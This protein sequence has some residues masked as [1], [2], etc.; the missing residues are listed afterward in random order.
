MLEFINKIKYLKVMFHEFSD[1]LKRLALTPVM[2]DQINRRLLTTGIID[3]YPIFKVNEHQVIAFRADVEPESDTP[4]IAIVDI[5]NGESMIICSGMESFIPIWIITLLTNVNSRQ[6]IYWQNIK[7]TEWESLTE[8]H[9]KLGGIDEIK[10][11]KEI[12]KNGDLHF[13]L[14]SNWRGDLDE[15]RLPEVLAMVAPSDLRGV[16]QKT[17]QK[18][19]QSS[20]VPDLDTSSF[21]TWQPPLDTSLA[22][23]SNPQQKNI[24]KKVLLAALRRPNSHDAFWA[25]ADGV[26]DFSGCAGKKYGP[27]ILTA[28]TFVENISEEWENPYFVS[29]KALSQDGPSYNGNDHLALVKKLKS[30]DDI[31]GAWQAALS[32]AFWI[33]KR[34]GIVHSDIQLLLGKLSLDV[35]SEVLQYFVKCNLIS[36]GIHL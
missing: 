7:D 30:V 11:L 2:D 35:P 10:Y 33:Y 26:S 36:M 31:C 16:F 1:D 27:P 6:W 18:I 12:L 19:K 17:L 32:A 24:L 23:L 15:T 14:S 21:S 9:R 22:I 8:F 3:C 25:E 13:V 4:G 34:Y 29:T 5:F 20:W 28:K